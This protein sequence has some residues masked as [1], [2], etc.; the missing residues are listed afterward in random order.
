MESRKKQLAVYSL[1]FIPFAGGLVCAFG[2][3]GCIE[4]FGGFAAM[5][6]SQP[7]EVATIG[8]DELKEKIARKDKF[9]LVE[10]LPAQYYNHDHLPGAINLPPDQ[11]AQLAPR[12]LPD[13]TAEIIVYCA[14]LT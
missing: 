11:I 13:K 5:P 2:A 12:V 7:V 1:V 9:V 8:R 4:G 6:E 14:K 3:P 10:T